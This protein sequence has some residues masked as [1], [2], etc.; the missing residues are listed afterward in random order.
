M[1]SA[2]DKSL[3]VQFV[4]KAHQWDRLNAEPGRHLG[5]AH[6]LVARNI[7]HHCRLLTRDRQPHLPSPTLELPLDQPRYVMHEKAEGAADFGPAPLELSARRLTSRRWRMHHFTRRHGGF[8][9]EPVWG[10]PKVLPAR[11]TGGTD[12]RPSGRTVRDRGR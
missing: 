10:H 12:A 7:E 1:G 5:L 9:Q 8:A 2:F 3:L 11:A 4:Q 6:P